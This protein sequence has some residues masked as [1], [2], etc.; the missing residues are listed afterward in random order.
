MQYPK[1]REDVLHPY[2]HLVYSQEPQLSLEP[3]T[4]P[5][6]QA[7][8]KLHIQQI[9][10]TLLFYARA[11]DLTMLMAINPIDAQQAHPT[12]LTAECMRHLLN[13]CAS[14]PNTLL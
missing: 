1:Y 5:E 14:H 11:V 6:V 10:G 2:T 4:S 9:W 3:D 8:E 7:N 13:Y 12:G